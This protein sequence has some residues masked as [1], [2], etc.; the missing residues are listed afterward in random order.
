VIINGT[1]KTL[2]QFLLKVVRQIWPDDDN[3]GSSYFLKH[4]VM[5]C[6]I[7]RMHLHT[8]FV[9]FFRVV[10]LSLHFSWLLQFIFL[11]WNM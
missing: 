3:I 11:N 1:F 9:C 7:F 6:G 2:V 5:D 4:N 8:F 10:M